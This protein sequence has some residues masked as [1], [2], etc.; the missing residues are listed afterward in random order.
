MRALIAHV[1]EGHGKRRG[2]RPLDAQIPCV[3]G[4][5]AQGVGASLG[6]HI[7]GRRWQQS[8]RRNCGK[9]IGRWSGCQSKRRSHG[10]WRAQRLVRQNRQV[11]RN[12]MAED[13]SEDAQIE[14]APVTRPNHGLRIRRPCDP[15]AR[16]P[17]VGS[18]APPHVGGNVPVARN[19]QVAVGRVSSGASVQFHQSAISLPV[20]RLREI[21]LIAQ[22]IIDRERWSGPP[23][24]LRVEEVALL[25]FLGIGG[26]TGNADIAIETGRHIAE[27]K[28]WPCPARPRSLR[29]K[30]VPERNSETGA[31]ASRRAR[32]GCAHSANQHRTYRR[33]FRRAWSSY[34]PAGTDLRARSAGSCS[35]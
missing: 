8:V 15:D 16:I 21:L 13:R 26:G 6:A 20:H 14:A 10:G 4:G 29:W 17:G 1:S 35:G 33:D 32:A 27:Y 25:E 5:Q 3:E 24:I 2:D 11:L 19:P 28:S 22:A 34:S 9:Y 30:S 31:V 23:G 12:H 7:K 18:G